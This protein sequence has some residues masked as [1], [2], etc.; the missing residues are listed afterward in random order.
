MKDLQKTICQYKELEADCDTKNF[1][2][3]E[4][5]IFI[6]FFETGQKQCDL[7]EKK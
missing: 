3:E 7:L 1:T 2:E 4:L 5:E 6:E